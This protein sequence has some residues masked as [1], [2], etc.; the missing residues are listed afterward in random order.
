M[1]KKKKKKKSNGVNFKAPIHSNTVIYA[2]S[3][4]QLTCIS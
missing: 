3:L 1:P 2:Y 4:V